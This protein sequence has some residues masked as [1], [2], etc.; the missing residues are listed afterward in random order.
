VRNNVDAARVG[1][2]CSTTTEPQPYPLGN[3]GKLWDMPGMIVLLHYNHLI[4]RVGIGS[5][6]LGNEEKDYF[7]TRGLCGFDAVL[8]VTTGRFDERET[9]L[10]QQAQKYNVPVLY[11]RQKVL[12]DITNTMSDD[13]VDENTAYKNVLNNVKNEIKA[14][15]ALNNLNESPVYCIDSKELDNSRLDGEELSKQLVTIGKRRN[16]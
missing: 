16:K 4:L 9:R 5:G 8:L 1:A 12:T 6:T 10:I 2:G 7:E 3:N 15:Q 11:I 14:A 13:G